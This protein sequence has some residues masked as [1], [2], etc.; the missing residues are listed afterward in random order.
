MRLPFLS[1]SLMCELH[2]V[3]HFRIELTPNLKL[4][5][6]I[7]ILKVLYNI[8]RVNV[9]DYSQL[10]PDRS[11]LGATFMIKNVIGYLL[12]F[13]SINVIIGDYF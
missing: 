1:Y 6:E 13:L 12:L 8:I 10:P 11:T 5:K 3:L 7:G 9:Y 4:R 2:I